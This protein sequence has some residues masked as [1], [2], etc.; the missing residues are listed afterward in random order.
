MRSYIYLLEGQNVGIFHIRPVSSG[1]EAK[2]GHFYLYDRIFKC[3]KNIRNDCFPYIRCPSNIG[4]SFERA[5]ALLRGSSIKDFKPR[6]P[7][8]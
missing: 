8:F 3:P 6:L 5:I 1:L 7:G 2:F 4:P